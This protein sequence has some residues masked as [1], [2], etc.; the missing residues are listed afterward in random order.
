MSMTHPFAK[1]RSF[2]K[3]G[4]AGAA[5]LGAPGLLHAQPAPIR[6]GILQPVTGAFAMDGGFGR[7]GAVMGIAKVNAMGGIKALGGARF[8]MVFADARSNARVAAQQVEQMNSQGVVAIIGGFASP[9]CMAASQMASR[10]NLPYIVDVG[11]ADQIIQRGLRNTFRFSPGFSLCTQAA[12]R[13][14][15]T[16]NDAAGRPSKTVVL[17]HEDGLF[18]SGLARMIATE[19]PRHGFELLDSIAHP[20]PARDMSDIALRIRSLKPDLII[21]SSYYEE[22]VLLM[23]TLQQ[24]RVRAK[25]VFSV[26]NGAASNLRFAKEFPLAAENIMDCNH[27]HDPRKPDGQELRRQVE[28]AGKPWNFNIVI[29]YSDVLLLADALER[30]GSMER[31][32]LIDA[33]ASSTFEGH[34]MPYGPT[35]FVDGQNIGAAPVMTQVQQGDIKVIFPEEFSDAKPNYPLPV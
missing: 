18:G 29:N 1:R 23:R 7:T 34:I 17:V 28:A 3:A 15:L 31:D 8:D 9:L 4:V 19:L 33:L 10:Y 6:V 5:V 14:L 2:I 25:G 30:A 27:W 20:T 12:I 21:P 32:A 26:L 16:I 13:N 35:R 11:V 24:Q 22:T